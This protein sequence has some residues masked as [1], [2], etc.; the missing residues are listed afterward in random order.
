MAA[1]ELFLGVFFRGFGRGP[2][3]IVTLLAI[4]AICLLGVFLYRSISEAKQSV[5]RTAELPAPAKPAEGGGDEGPGTYG[6]PY[7]RHPKYPPGGES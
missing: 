5:K 2:V 7:Q 6:G 4:A 3:L 1:N